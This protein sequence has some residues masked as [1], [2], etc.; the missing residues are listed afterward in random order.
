MDAARLA[1]LRRELDCARAVEHLLKVLVLVE[2]G[3]RV[4]LLRVVEQAEDAQR[5]GALLDA[6]V[7]GDVHHVGRRPVEIGFVDLLRPA[8]RLVSELLF[9]FLGSH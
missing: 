9:V 1:A 8:R 2:L 5:L 6:V 7:L 4:A 3:A